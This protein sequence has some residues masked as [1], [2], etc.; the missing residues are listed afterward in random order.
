MIGDL[1]KRETGKTAQEHIPLKV[2][3]IAQEKIFD[4]SKSVKEIA[5]ELWCKYPQHFNRLFKSE[6]G[7]TTS[8]E[9]RVRMNWAVPAVGAAAAMRVQKK[10]S[11]SYAFF[12]FAPTRYFASPAHASMYFVLGPSK[13]RVVPLNE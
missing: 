10:R 1:I 7:Y 9:G 13:N 2:I 5:Y 11:R 12:T 4:T 8:I 6:T 3:D